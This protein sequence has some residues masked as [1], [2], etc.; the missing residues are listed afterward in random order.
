[1]SVPFGRSSVA[2]PSAL[3]LLLATQTGLPI[4]ELTAL[5]RPGFNGG[6]VLPASAAARG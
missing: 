5:N 2:M 3:F 4:S 1:M 6:R